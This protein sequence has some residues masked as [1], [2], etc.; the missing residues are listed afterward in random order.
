MPI[1][2]RIPQR[3]QTTDNVTSSSI[4][5]SD[6]FSVRTRRGSASGSV[7]TPDDFSSFGKPTDPTAQTPMT[8]SGLM[9]R[10]KA[11]GKS[12]KRQASEATTPGGTVSSNEVPPTPGDALVPAAPKPAQQI[13]MSAPFNPPT[14]NEAPTLPIPPHTGII[15]A[16][17]ATSGWTTLY[18]GQVSSTGADMHVLEDVMPMWLLEYL[19]VNRVPAVPLNKI[20]FVLLPFPAKDPRDQLPELLNTAQSKL[21]AS[22]FLRVRKLTNHVQDKLDRMTGSQFAT[23]ASSNTPRSSFDSR[24]RSPSTSHRESDSRPRPE[25]I[26]EIVCNDVVLPLDMT[27]AAVRQYVWRQAGELSMYYRRRMAVSTPP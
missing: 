16:E 11:F 21:T 1:P 24:S 19:L 5:P 25:D 4:S 7:T 12:N 17:E 15:I 18:R 23:P 13:L 26:Y 14:T 20:S 3:S 9:G 22:R 8:P 2:L 6:Y 27:L 10:L